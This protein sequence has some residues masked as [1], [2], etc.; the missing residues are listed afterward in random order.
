MSTVNVKHD[1]YDVYIGRRNKS[2]NLEQS[3]YH[4]PYIVGKDGTRAEC[5]CKFENYLLGNTYILNRIDSLRDKVKGCWCAKPG[6]I[7]TIRDNIICHGQ[8][9]DRYLYERS[10]A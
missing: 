10:L 7:L 2:Y 5:L 8:I 3:I 9:I 4:N 1:S 6:Q